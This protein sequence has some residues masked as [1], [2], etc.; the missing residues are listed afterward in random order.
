[1]NWEGGWFLRRECMLFHQGLKNILSVCVVLHQLP[2]NWLHN[3]SWGI[4]F[5]L[6]FN[7]TLS[8]CAFPYHTHAHT[9]TQV[10]WN[11]TH[12]LETSHLC[13]M[14]VTLTTTLYFWPLFDWWWKFQQVMQC[15][16]TDEP[17]TMMAHQ[18]TLWQL[19]GS[20][21]LHR[22]P[23]ALSYVPLIKDDEW[24]LTAGGFSHCIHGS[25][26]TGRM[27]ALALSWRVC[28]HLFLYKWIL[29]ASL[30]LV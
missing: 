10:H 1:M 6:S 14:F 28:W 16:H 4:C 17:E 7:Q 18:P 2:H 29:F 19:V 20:P 21:S 23:H 15:F 22:L 12:D 13:S 3:P 8:L 26:E 25:T 30:V 5:P 27:L 24:S 9:H 11:S